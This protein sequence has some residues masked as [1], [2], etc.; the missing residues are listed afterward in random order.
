MLSCGQLSFVKRKVV[1]ILTVF[2]FIFGAPRGPP[3]FFKILSALFVSMTRSVLVVF[4]S[5][6]TF[7]FTSEYGKEKFLFF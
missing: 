6:V 3:G 7:F 1:K 2:F 5:N 4:Q